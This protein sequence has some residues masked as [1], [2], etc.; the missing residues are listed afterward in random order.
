MVFMVVVVVVVMLMLKIPDDRGPSHLQ[1][2]E[3]SK[4]LN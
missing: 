4:G 1:H 2:R 3:K